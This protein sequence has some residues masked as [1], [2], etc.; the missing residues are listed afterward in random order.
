ME[1]LLESSGSDIVKYSS[2][3]YTR[4]K[5]DIAGADISGW[6]LPCYVLKELLQRHK[7]RMLVFMLSIFCLF[8]QYYACNAIYEQEGEGVFCGDLHRYLEPNEEGLFKDGINYWFK[9]YWKKNF[10]AK[11]DK[12]KDKSEKYNA[13]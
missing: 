1:E 11:I 6:C 4:V 9:A 8:M 12:I 2:S 3:H 7:K 13:R 5:R 10:Q